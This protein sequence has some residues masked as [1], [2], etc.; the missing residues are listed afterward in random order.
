MKANRCFALQWLSRTAVPADIYE[1]LGRLKL[2]PRIEELQLAARDALRELQSYH[3]G[4]QAGSAERAAWLKTELER[5]AELL[6]NPHQLKQYQR[7]LL[8]QWRIEL[9]AELSHHGDDFNAT[10]EWLHRAKHIHPR[11]L[12]RVAR[13]LI[14]PT[15]RRA[16]TS[17]TQQ[18]QQS[19]LMWRSWRVVASTFGFVALVVL[20]ILY[21]NSHVTIVTT[22]MASTAN[23]VTAGTSQMT[24]SVTSGPAAMSSVQSVQDQSAV[25]E[26]Q[27]HTA[28][29]AGGKSERTVDSVTD[30]TPPRKD[31]ASSKSAPKIGVRSS[32]QTPA[33][34]EIVDVRA[35][36]AQS[37][38]GDLPADFAFRELFEVH[39]PVN[40][41]AVMNRVSD[42]TIRITKRLTDGGEL[43]V[44]TSR[45]AV[46]G[47]GQVRVE[48]KE[49]EQLSA[50]IMLPGYR[51]TFR[52]HRGLTFQLAGGSLSSIPPI[53]ENSTNLRFMWA[54][55]PVVCF[56][57]GRFIGIWD[58]IHRHFSSNVPKTEGHFEYTAKGTSFFPTE[59]EPPPELPGLEP[60]IEPLGYF[61]TRELP[62]RSR[63]LAP[64]DPNSA[65]TVI[66]FDIRHE[67][68]VPSERQFSQIVR[69]LKQKPE[70]VPLSRDYLIRIDPGSFRLVLDGS[71]SF[72]GGKYV[73]YL[74]AGEPDFNYTFRQ[75]FTSP[76]N[77]NQMARVAVAWEGGASDK[78]DTVAF[79]TDGIKL[80]DVPESLAPSAFGLASVKAIE[81]PSAN[82]PLM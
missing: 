13:L 35:P 3:V 82:S 28:S 30:S 22:Q 75:S 80:L 56:R 15:S 25:G 7:Q 32:L 23:I 72:I 45:D 20:A 62:T 43:V 54:P 12:D 18:H 63:S 67:K 4:S 31:T 69:A 51:K 81:R 78:T 79:K 59:E 11:Q 21:F 19:S 53:P 29:E 71:A 36:M 52:P 70:D 57:D 8:Q 37:D 60:A 41:L 58:P 14:S 74:G 73:A 40:L 50:V 27:S 6:A 10:R 76:V 64:K 48:S 33:D 24:G 34:S 65:F 47:L 2:D 66:V 16:S 26:M 42:R 61:I 77:P 55:E 1:L 49:A 39:G 68:L 44:C 5:A 9:L 46:C 17:M 38:Y